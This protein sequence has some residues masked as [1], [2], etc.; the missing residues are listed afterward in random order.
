MPHIE[1]NPRE[2]SEQ[3]VRDAIH[4]F[5]ARDL[6]AILAVADREIVLR[7]LLTEAERPL[8]HGHEGV[9]E[10]FEAVFGVFP[11]W[12]PT[13]RAATHDEDGAVVVPLDVTAT[14]AGSGVPIDQSYWLGARVRDAKIVFFGFFR[15]EEDATRAVT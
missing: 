8:Y 1:E 10:W 7:S 9:R 14:A 4:A 3:L 12:N 11:D 5:M 13:P 6:E 2:M 15:T